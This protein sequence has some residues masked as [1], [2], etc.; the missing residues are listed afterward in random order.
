MWEAPEPAYR[1]PQGQTAIMSDCLAIWSAMSLI[2]SDFG[3]WLTII[4][5]YAPQDKGQQVQSKYRYTPYPTNRVC[6]RWNSHSG[7][8][9]IGGKNRHYCLRCRDTNHTAL[10][11]PTTN[12]THPHPTP[13]SAP[14]GDEFS[15]PREAL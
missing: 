5:H 1:Q 8:H 7:C 13:K 10:D 3:R 4:I 15:S 6:F 11:C 14:A 9:L 12:S 2:G